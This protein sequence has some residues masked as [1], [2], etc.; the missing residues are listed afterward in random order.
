MKTH[1]L[2]DEFPSRWDNLLL[3]SS[4]GGELANF[5]LFKPRGEQPPLLPF[6]VNCLRNGRQGRKKKHREKTSPVREKWTDRGL[7]GKILVVLGAEGSCPQHVQGVD[8]DQGACQVLPALGDGV[9]HLV[10]P[11][12]QLLDDIP[13]A[14][15]HLAA[16]GQQEVVC[17][18]PHGLGRGGDRREVIRAQPVIKETGLHFSMQKKANSSFT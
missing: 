13:V 18:L 5:G 9:L 2:P 17:W 4:H 12:V 15:P 16:P 6:T 1:P 7:D 3:I 11:R 10:Q 8:E 14:V